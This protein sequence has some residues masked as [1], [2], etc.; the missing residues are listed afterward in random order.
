MDF[1]SAAAAK[2]IATLATI[3][4]SNQ[5]M[6]FVHIDDAL[7]GSIYG[8]AEKPQGGLVISYV[9]E[10]ADRSR[11]EL[12]LDEASV[13]KSTRDDTSME[14]RDAQRSVVQIAPEVDRRS[15]RQAI[16]C[17]RIANGDINGE[18]M[19]T[20]LE[21]LESQLWPMLE[22]DRT[23]L[24][25]LWLP[26]L[27]V[28]RV[29]AAVLRGEAPFTTAAVHAIGAQLRERGVISEVHTPVT[30][31]EE[32]LF[33]HHSWGT[34]MAPNNAVP[35]IAA[36]VM[37]NARTDDLHKRTRVSRELILA[38]LLKRAHRHYQWAP[39]TVTPR[40]VEAMQAAGLVDKAPAAAHTDSD[41]V[42]EV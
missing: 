1:T 21:T 42:A 12:V 23:Q 41:S 37:T 40:Y 11:C 22:C 7:L 35:R 24:A 16:A 25:Q 32:W 18:L 36:N 9:A 13:R 8:V 26:F 33:T 2:H 27:N 30:K 14:L 15:F 20:A 6:L 39:Q 31:L 28:A 19:E 10:N 38:A 5:W 34:L 3:C 29:E 17:M 4:A